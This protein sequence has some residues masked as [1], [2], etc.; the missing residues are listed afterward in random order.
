[1][2][3]LSFYKL[4]VGTAGMAIGAT[5]VSLIQMAAVDGAE[6]AR[7]QHLADIAAG[8]TPTPRVVVRLADL[9]CPN[10]AVNRAAGPE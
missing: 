1:M 4:L 5:L 3:A 2:E 7:L 8:R 9:D 10:V 6:S